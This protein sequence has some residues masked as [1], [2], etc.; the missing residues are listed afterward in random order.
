MMN[1]VT[2]K[3][4]TN[5]PQ[6]SSHMRARPHQTTP[7]AGICCFE[8]T[9]NCVLFGEVRKLHIIVSRLSL[10]RISGIQAHVSLQVASK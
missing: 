1:V 9:Y 2:N 8:Q 10:S 3:P 7:R 5:R 6:N 4:W